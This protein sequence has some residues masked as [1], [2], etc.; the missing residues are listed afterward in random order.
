MRAFDIPTDALEQAEVEAQLR[1]CV[2]EWVGRLARQDYA[3]ALDM[4]LR[5]APEG[6]RWPGNGDWT[7]QQLGNAIA[8][9]GVLEDPG[10]LDRPFKVVPLAGELLDTFRSR[11]TVWFG[12]TRS[13]GLPYLGSVEADLPLN[14]PRGDAVGDLT[15]RFLLRQIGERRMA[16]VLLD[17]HVC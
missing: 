16:L 17:V 12:A 14:Y 7:P 9:H 1:A 11:M 13:F 5:E 6:P 8:F 4:I 10:D 3:G 15:S 2:E